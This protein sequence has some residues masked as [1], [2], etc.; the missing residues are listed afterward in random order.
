MGNQQSNEK[1]KKRIIFIEPRQKESAKM[2]S[3]NFVRK[4]AKADFI[5]FYFDNYLFYKDGDFKY[6]DFSFNKEDTS[7]EYRLGRLDMNYICKHNHTKTFSYDE[8]Y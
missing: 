2:I 1:P 6:I 5:R 8:E 3:Y 7:I 4:E